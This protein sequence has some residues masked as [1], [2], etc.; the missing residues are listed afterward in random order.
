VNL[1]MFELQNGKPDAAW[2]TIS[3]A[4]ELGRTLFRDRPALLPALALYGELAGERGDPAAAEASCREAD[5]LALA[6][7]GPDD[8]ERAFPLHCL[9]DARRR[10]GAVDEAIALATE[11]VRI[12]DL[13]G[14]PH[15]PVNARIVLAE[16]LHDAGATRRA[17]AVIADARAFATGD[18][19]AYL[20]AV[21]EG[22]K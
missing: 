6:A 5:A 19:P 16:A 4:V 17:R 12:A 9:A 15:D 10:Q 2:A 14:R 8:P 21:I 20:D 13:G 1:A 22:W 7:F 11:A 18:E 3:A